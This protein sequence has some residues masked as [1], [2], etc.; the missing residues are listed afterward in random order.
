MQANL[1]SIFL[2]LA[3]IVVYVAAKVRYYM[4]VSD[5][6]WRRVDKSKLVDWSDDKDSD[7]P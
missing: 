7:K 6:Q 4:R 3:I 1:T 2:L 5:E